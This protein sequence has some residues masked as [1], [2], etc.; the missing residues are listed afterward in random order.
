MC[1]VWIQNNIVCALRKLVVEKNE[2][3][4]T[5]FYCLY[6]VREEED[7]KNIKCFEKRNGKSSNKMI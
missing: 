6:R 2:N 7:H 5:F 1:V 4:Q 3:L